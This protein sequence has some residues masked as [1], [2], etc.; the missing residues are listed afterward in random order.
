MRILVKEDLG[1]E[2]HVAVQQQLLTPNAQEMR[3]ERFQNSSTS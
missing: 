3:K 2:S 1:L